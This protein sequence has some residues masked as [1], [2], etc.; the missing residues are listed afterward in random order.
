MTSKFSPF[1]ALK[2]ISFRNFLF[3]AFVSEIGNQMQT[4]AVAWQVY[5]ITRNPA[6]LGL[7]G[8]ANFLPIILFSLV[9]GLVADNM[10]RKKLLVVSQL[11]MAMVTL[12]LF[13]FTHFQIINPWII[14]ALL[15]L[16]STASS[17]ALP[18]RQAV[19]PN[20]V[21]QNLLMNAVSLNTLQFQGATM[22]GPAIAGVLI[23]SFGVESVYL[24][25][26]FS[27]I[28]FVTAVLTL[29]VS[30]KVEKKVAMHVD[31]ILEGIKFV[32]KTPILY[33]TMILDFLATFLGTATL[34]MPVF[35]K[36]VLNV[37][38]TGLG[39]LYSAPAI[40]GVIAGLSMS[41]IHQIKSQGRVII[42]AVIL[43][44]FAIIGFG[45]S[46]ILPVSLMFLAL[47]GFGDM[48]STIIRNTIRQMVTPDHLR[49]RM[50][51]VM[52]IFFQGGP[53]LGEI[54]AG[55]LAKAIGGPAAVVLGGAGVVIITSIIAWRSKNLREYKGKDLTI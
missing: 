46:K 26:S 24:F 48:V 23:A 13:T 51:S 31:S 10:D 4:V 36:E 43:Y 6:S 34:L 8:L 9:G 30:L 35:A 28:A 55:F 53:Q 37:G 20:L 7:I 2:V 44:G 42:A 18:A 47:M 15:F 54:E 27:F 19:I 39:L 45:F 16:H 21:P 33:L 49:G 50:V 5:E 40:G 38:P 41:S 29:K 1:L 22:I 17:F 25:N 32:L 11:A 14:Y 12:T 3:G 52:R